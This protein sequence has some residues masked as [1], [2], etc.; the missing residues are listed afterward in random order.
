MQYN[1]VAD[2]SVTGMLCLTV[3]GCSQK[4][5]WYIKNSLLGFLLADLCLFYDEVSCDL[6]PI[7]PMS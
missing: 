3:I 6:S 2:S 5:W 7:F 1:V 4:S